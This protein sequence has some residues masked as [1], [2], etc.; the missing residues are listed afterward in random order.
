LN[1]WT[2]YGS[3]RCAITK[4]EFR[5]IWDRWALPSTGNKAAMVDA[6]LLDTNLTMCVE[7][8]NFNHSHID[9]SLLKGDSYVLATF[10]IKT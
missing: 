10:L 9:P 5:K 2:G 7:I 4:S 8:T 3:I 1:T 6:L